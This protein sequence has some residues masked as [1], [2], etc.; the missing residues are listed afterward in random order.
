M[1]T[2]S[3]ASMFAKLAGELAGEPGV[4]LADGSKKSFGAGTLK[5][6]GKIFAMVTSAGQFV[7]KL[8]RQRVEDLE[9]RGTGTKFDPGHGRLMKEWLQVSAPQL[10][11]CRVLAKEALAFVSSAA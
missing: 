2:P 7:V 4:E 10:G 5:V 6:N 11:Q 1:S 3:I 8:P 9:A